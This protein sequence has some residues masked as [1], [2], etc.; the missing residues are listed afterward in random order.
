MLVDALL[1]DSV[2]VAADEVHGD[3][4]LLPAKVARKEKR[5]R[6]HLDLERHVEEGVKV[7]LA[8]W[9]P[10]AGR[11]WR[12]A[13]PRALLLLLLLL[14]LRGGGGDE[15]AQQQPR[16]QQREGEVAAEQHAVPADQRD[17]D[18]GVGDARSRRVQ[19]AG[20]RGEEERARGRDGDEDDEAEQEEGALASLVRLSQEEHPEGEAPDLRSCSRSM[21][22]TLAGGATACVSGSVCEWQRV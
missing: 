15:V 7:E 8:L 9:P 1:V 5:V 18:G 22:D 14:L 19:P 3:H 21:S 12:R 4:A 11:R 13:E 2:A 17:D 6:H 10:A 20:E 16:Q